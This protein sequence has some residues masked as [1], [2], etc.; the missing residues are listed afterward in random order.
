MLRNYSL[1]LLPILF[2]IPS[3][4]GAQQPVIRYTISIPQPESHKYHVEL[5]TEG[6]SIDTL[7]LKLPKWTPGYYQIMDYAKA[8]GNIAL[9]DDKGKNLSFDKVSD[10][11]LRITGAKKKTLI[12]SYDVETTRKFVATSY[13]DA[14]QVF[15]MWKTISIAPF[16]LSSKILHGEILLLVLVL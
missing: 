9:K 15:F 14:E 10:N 16:M 12:L 7:T 5:R 4:C 3:F 11:T 1:L 8:L 13:V 6:W 2:L